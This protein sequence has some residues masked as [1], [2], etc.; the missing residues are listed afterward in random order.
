MG[1]KGLRAVSSLGGLI[2]DK[3]GLYSGQTSAETLIPENLT[4]PS[5]VYQKAGKTV[6]QIAE[7]LLPSS[8]IAKAEKGLSL[9]PKMLTEAGVVGGQTAIQNG[10]IDNDTKTA[11]II[12]AVFPVVGA[13]LSKAKGL[14]KPIGE[15]IQ[16]T[17]IRPTSRDLADGFKI[18]NVNKYGLGGSLA[19]TATKVHVKLNE[20]GQKLQST[21]KSSST[22]VN[23]NDVYKNTFNDLLSVS[24]SINLTST[25]TFFNEEVIYAKPTGKR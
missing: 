23:L 4:T 15:K 22:A 18:E 1:E 11:A 8:K 6:E 13:G 2:P 7:F 12:G 25:P 10:K 14:L 17:V 9:I 24:K 3:T 19:Q 21:L 16:T 20:L 5:N